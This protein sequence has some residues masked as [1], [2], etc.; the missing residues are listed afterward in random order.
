M[1]AHTVDAQ[2]DIAISDSDT[3][4]LLSHFIEQF[5]LYPGICDGKFVGDHGYD[6][7]KIYIL[8]TIADINHG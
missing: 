7:N 5:V 1:H 2:V 8:D 4:K 3:Y 6:I